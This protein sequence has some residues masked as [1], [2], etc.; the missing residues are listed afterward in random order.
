MISRAVA[1]LALLVAFVAASPITDDPRQCNGWFDGVAG[2]C[3]S[4]GD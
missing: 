1:T 2:A 3:D 4:I